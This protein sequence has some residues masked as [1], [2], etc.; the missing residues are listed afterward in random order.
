MMDL[1]KYE[2]KLVYKNV[3]RDAY[4]AEDYRLRL[5]F[6][7]DLEKKFGLKFHPKRDRL[8]EIAWDDGHSCGYSEVYWT[9]EKLSE[10]LDKNE[11]RA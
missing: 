6:K 2:N 9:Y 1:K 5:L 4:R 7:A 10:L 3:S 8:F 11:G